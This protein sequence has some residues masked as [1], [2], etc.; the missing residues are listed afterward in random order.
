MIGSW[1][2]FRWEWYQKIVYEYNFYK[3][4]KADNNGLYYNGML[5][6]TFCMPY[7]KRLSG[8]KVA[9]HRVTLMSCSNV[10]GSDK[11]P[12]IFIN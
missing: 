2:S 1:K 11:L 7:E 9:K 6:D 5:S 12:L 4:Y 8:F 3:I 10:N